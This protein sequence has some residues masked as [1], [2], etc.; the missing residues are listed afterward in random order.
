MLRIKAERR[1]AEQGG[2]RAGR[3]LE[4][5]RAAAPWHRVATDI[6]A[7]IWARNSTLSAVQVAGLVRERL[8]AA[9]H[10][11]ADGAPPSERTVRR[12]IAAAKPKR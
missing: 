12:V 3:N 9:G 6:A 11:S 7:R 2:N 10:F 4:R 8:E 5:K 1:Y